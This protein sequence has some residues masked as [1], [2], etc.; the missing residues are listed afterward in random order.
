[1]DFLHITNLEEKTANI[2]L[3]S[4]IQNG[5]SQQFLTEFQYLDSLNLDSISILINSKGGDVFEGLGVVSTIQN[6]K[7]HTITVNEGIAASTAGWILAA[8]NERHAKDFSQTMI[9]AVSLGGRQAT[10]KEEKT[11]LQK[12]TQSIVKVFEN[13]TKMEVE[14]IESLMGGTNFLSATE[15]LELGIIDKI[16]STKRK[17]SNSINPDELLNLVNNNFEDK[18]I[19]KKMELITNHFGLDK[20]AKEET[21]LQSIENVELKHKEEL[22]SLK[23]ELNTLKG[24]TVLTTVENAIKDGKIKEADK[25][26]MVEIATNSLDVFNTIIEAIQVVKP[27][28]MDGIENKVVIDNPRK[29]WTIEKYE[30]EAPELLNE[31]RINDFEAYSILFKNEYGVNPTK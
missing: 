2:N 25:E 13:N 14:K 4:T 23:N 20:E 10:N 22:D 31:M 3:F 15:A 5:T 26:K 17:I 28:L 6:A 11:V 29:E 16:I 9:H 27:S 30:I 8:G 18:P 19:I 24:A 21:I 12:I 7:T 1:M